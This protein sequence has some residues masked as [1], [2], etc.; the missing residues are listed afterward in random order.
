[1]TCSDGVKEAFASLV[2]FATFK[3]KMAN[4]VA[5]IQAALESSMN[6][7]TE[8]SHRPALGGGRWRQRG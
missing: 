8:A 7:I 2:G 5:Q 6:D 1:M 4:E 3:L